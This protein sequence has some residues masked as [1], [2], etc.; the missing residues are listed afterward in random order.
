[1]NAMGLAL[2]LNDEN[3]LI[4]LPFEE[5]KGNSKSTES[6]LSDS[7]YAED[8]G[9]FFSNDSLI[10][11][12]EWP[13]DKYTTLL[14]LSTKVNLSKVCDMIRRTPQ[15]AENLA[16]KYQEESRSNKGRFKWK[17]YLPLQ[18]L[19]STK[20]YYLTEKYHKYRKSYHESKE[21]IAFRK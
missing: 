5:E 12:I 9:K 16:K 20:F 13:K 1:M 4:S 18:F 21:K 17:N 6:R 15:D 3:R 19:I 8:L 2:P 7:Y 14:T 10:E 11:P